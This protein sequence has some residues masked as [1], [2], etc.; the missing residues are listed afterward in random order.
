[1]IAAARRR[2]LLKTAIGCWLI[3]LFGWSAGAQLL[4]P[5][6]FADAL[7]R[8]GLVSPRAAPAMAY[9]LP[10]AELIVASSLAAYPRNAIAW[11]AACFLTLLFTGVHAYLLISGD[12][13]DCGCLGLQATHASGTYHVAL[14]LLMGA[15]ALGS[16]YSLFSQ[17]STTALPHSQPG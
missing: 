12:V 13:I 1:M 10:A 11:L 14:C 8:S 7:R 4:W 9:A 5:A 3:V 6:E 16:F 17:T 2:A 15:S